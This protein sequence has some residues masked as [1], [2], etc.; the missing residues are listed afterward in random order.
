[1]LNFEDFE[2]R[3]MVAICLGCDV[4]PDRGASGVGP[5]AIF[6]LLLEFTVSGDYFKEKLKLW[7]QKKMKFAEDVIDSY[8]S[9]LV[10]EPCNDNQNCDNFLYLDKQP[11]SLPTYLKEFTKDDSIV[12]DG[13][14]IKVCTGFCG[15]SHK[16]LGAE[17]SYL[18]SSCQKCVCLTC[19]CKLGEK[20]C[21]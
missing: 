15:V 3:A 14:E 13:P 19:V 6:K 10:F 17:C 7:T 9:A 11:T 20:I 2:T 18:C 16:F 5:A 21:V 8:I 12:V 4:T 1:M